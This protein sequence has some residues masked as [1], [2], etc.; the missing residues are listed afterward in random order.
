MMACANESGWESVVWLGP[1]PAAIIAVLE[2]LFSVLLSVSLLGERMSTPQRGGG[3]LIM[4]GVVF[5]RIR[6]GS[7]HP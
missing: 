5:V 4:I 3:I 7:E 2:L 6:P 1:T